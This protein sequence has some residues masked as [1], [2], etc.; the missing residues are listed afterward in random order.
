MAKNEK[1]TKSTPLR[2]TGDSYRDSK[3]WEY[4]PEGNMAPDSAAIRREQANEIQRET[5]GKLTRTQS[6][7]ASTKM[8]NPSRYAAGGSVKGWG[9]AR[10]GK[11]CKV[12]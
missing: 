6:L 2:F 5:R 8:G 3:G 4:M 11:A 7:D 9:K 10:S 12:Y 1:R